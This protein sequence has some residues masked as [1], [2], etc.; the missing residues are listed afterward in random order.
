MWGKHDVQCII[1]G[2]LTKGRA[3]EISEMDAV[4]VVITER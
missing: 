3:N 4:G 1:N 2:N